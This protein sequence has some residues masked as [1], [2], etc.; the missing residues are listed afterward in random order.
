MEYLIFSAIIILI[1]DVVTTMPGLVLVCA[2]STH[3]EYK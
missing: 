2:L 1:F 3:P